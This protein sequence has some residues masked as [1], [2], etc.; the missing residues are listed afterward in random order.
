M[1]SAKERFHAELQQY[2]LEEFENSTT[3]SKELVDIWQ[4]DID[5][6]GSFIYPE[7]VEQSSLEV[8]V[9]VDEKN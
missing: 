6:D 3:F 9:S 5:S 4:W 1:E 2:F 8:K 7:I